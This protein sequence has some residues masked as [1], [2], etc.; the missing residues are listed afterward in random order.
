MLERASFHLTSHHLSPLD[1]Q[2]RSRLCCWLH[3]Q[4]MSWEICSC[5]FLLLLHPCLCAPLC[6]WPPSFQQQ[7]AWPFSHPA[8]CP[9]SLS[10]AVYLSLSHVGMWG[11]L[12]SHHLP[13]LIFSSLSRLM[14]LFFTHSLM[15]KHSFTTLSQWF[16]SPNTLFGS[17]ICFIHHDGSLL[18]IICV[19]VTLFININD[20]QI[21][22]MHI[23]ICS[24]G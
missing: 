22:T 21:T 4:M 8:L 14:R 15:S 13:R 23:N 1:Q 20:W 3:S 11:Y 7:T 16:I 24:S 5:L 18:H 19:N 2:A 6:P 12:S 10:Q 9:S 17:H